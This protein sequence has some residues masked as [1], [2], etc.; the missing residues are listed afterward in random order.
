MPSLY[1]CW[2]VLNTHSSGKKMEGGRLE[3]ASNSTKP[4]PAER[5]ITLDG[6]CVDAVVVNYILSD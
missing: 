4:Q 2:K 3:N 6:R 5:S 1:L